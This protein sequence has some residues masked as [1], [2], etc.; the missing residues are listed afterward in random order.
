MKMKRI[1]MISLFF[2]LGIALTILIFSAQNGEKSGNSSE[3]ITE[4]FLEIFG[5]ENIS[6]GAFLSLE[7]IIRKLAHFFEY[8]ILSAALYIFVWTYGRRLLFTISVSFFGT[9]LYALTDEFH[10]YFVPER[11]A[12]F[13]DV[14]L[15]TG[16]ALCGVLTV[17]LI[18][19]LILRKKG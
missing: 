6:S 4:K 8:Y 17:M 2:V 18:M 9:V 14:L 12:S 11:Q 5:G 7:T 1:R 16:G 15:D 3:Q 13:W 19:H 10:Q